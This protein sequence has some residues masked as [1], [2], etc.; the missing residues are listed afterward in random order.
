MHL[1]SHGRELI[2]HT[3]SPPSPPEDCW[4]RCEHPGL[5]HRLRLGFQTWLSELSPEGMSDWQRLVMF[6]HLCAIPA[7]VFLCVL[8]IRRAYEGRTTTML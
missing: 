8:C 3:A 1:D 6:F 7:L 5:L 4:P 2:W